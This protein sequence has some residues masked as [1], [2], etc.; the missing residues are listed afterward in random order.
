MGFFDAFEQAAATTMQGQQI[1]ADLDGK[2]ADTALREQQV[3]ASKVEQ[4]AKQRQLDD[5]RALADWM[6]SDTALQDAA[7]TTAEDSAQQFARA[8]KFAAV[9]GDFD[10]A[11]Q[12]ADLANNAIGV[13]GKAQAQ[14]EKQEVD[15]ADNL[16]VVAQDVMSNP[17]PENHKALYKSAIK[18]GVHPDSI[19]MP[20][21]TEYAAFVNQS[22]IASMK[23][24]ERMEFLVK[25]REA[26]DRA[27]AVKEEQ[28]RR[29]EDRDAARR[30]RATAQQGMLAIAKGNQE[31]AKGN[32][33]LRKQLAASTEEARKAKSENANLGG[34]IGFRQTVAAVNYAN[35]VARGLDLIGTMGK[36]QTASAF[37]HLDNPH[38]I[39]SALQRTGTNKM[40][41]ELTQI[42]QTATKG[43]GLEMAQ[44]ATAGSG[45]SANKDVIREMSDMVAAAPGDK[46]YEILFKVSNAAHFALVRMEAIPRSADPRIQE[47]REKAEASLKKYPHPAD[48]YA[49]AEANGLKMGKLKKKQTSML[50]ALASKISGHNNAAPPPDIQS[51]MDQYP[52][53]K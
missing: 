42:Y 4:A 49:A 50:E 18:A 43:L 34:A 10:G 25:R 41:P 21:T 22:A 32:L 24:K 30:D 26:E 9:R 16:S 51:I 3:V 36:S 23:G 1:L 19:P 13:A 33:E 47:I 45:R 48:V 35:E 20:G 17:T 6:R 46:E 14:R 31:I 29:D 15:N 8:S 5:N 38:N 44:L 27:K 52:A 7:A 39:M 37:A 53:S 2:K 40:T 28:L 11:K 12:M